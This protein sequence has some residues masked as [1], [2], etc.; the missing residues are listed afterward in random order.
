MN[1]QRDVVVLPNFVAARQRKSGVTRRAALTGLVG[2][3]LLLH[4]LQVFLA[5]RADLEPSSGAHVSLD[6]LPVFTE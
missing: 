2:D 6:L 1:Q 3:H 5:V 4:L